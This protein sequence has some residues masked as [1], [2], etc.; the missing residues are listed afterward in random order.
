M[1]YSTFLSQAN[2]FFLKRGIEFSQDSNGGFSLWRRFNTETEEMGYNTHFGFMVFL[3]ERRIT[4][5]KFHVA[6]VDT[7]LETG[8][9]TC[10]FVEIKFKFDLDFLVEVTIKKNGDGVKIEEINLNIFDLVSL[11]EK[12][13]EIP[14]SDLYFFEMSGLT[15]T[16][17]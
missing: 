4:E 12:F 15:L 2:S 1:E 11:F 16:I 9:C 7:Y 3:D 14:F 5:I 10:L 8:E 6:L 13:F 17:L